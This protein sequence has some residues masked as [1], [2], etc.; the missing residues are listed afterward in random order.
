MKYFRE[1]LNWQGQQ[2]MM[3]NYSARNLP[4]QQQQHQFYLQQQQQVKQ[5]GMMYPQQAVSPA[6]MP[7]VSGNGTYYPMPTR[8]TS[9]SSQQ[10][11]PGPQFQYQPAT[12]PDQLRYNAHQQYQQ[13]QQQMMMMN[14][15]MSRSAPYPHP[16]EIAMKRRMAQQQQQQQP[17]NIQQ[18]PLQQVM[19]PMS[20][21]N[22]AQPNVT[23]YKVQAPVVSVGNNNPH[24]NREQGHVQ[25]PPQNN[26]QQMA[27][28]QAHHQQQL[29]AAQQ[30]R[31]QQQQQQQ[32]Q[33]QRGYQQI[34]SPPL[35]QHQPP[36]PNSKMATV[37]GP[38]VMSPQPQQIV[39]VENPVRQL[40]DTEPRLTLTVRD[41][42]ILEP[43]KLQHL[44]SVSNH[45]FLLRDQVFEMLM[46]RTK[47]F[48][49]QLKC[50]HNEDRFRQ[51]SWPAS[52]EV[53]VNNHRL[54]I[55]RSEHQQ[56]PQQMAIKNGATS[57]KPLF[58][59][60]MCNPGENL[61]TIS[62]S[63]CCCSHLFV[64]ELVQRPTLQNLERQIFQK[65]LLPK[66]QSIAK[67]KQVFFN[68]NNSAPDRPVLDQADQE[69]S[70][71]AETVPLRCPYT[72]QMVQIPTRSIECRHLRCFDLHNFLFVNRD[73]PVWQCP[74]CARPVGLDELEI[75]QFILEI[76]RYAQ[77]NS[78]SVCFLLFLLFQNAYFTPT[79]FS[80]DDG[81]FNQ[82]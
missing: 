26:P 59:K 66:D 46:D 8:T 14:S 18:S 6:M 78:T 36:Y 52:V 74:L 67:L 13:Q 33:A 3:P 64:L 76:I 29:I 20:P 82:C 44:L 4:P 16:H 62:V 11:P 58:I 7:V 79:T 56:T 39:K 43:F 40:E 71:T 73:K 31:L 65:K 15:H 35:Q 50:F 32:Q 45:K 72:N 21:M 12:T 2:Q 24:F 30:Q 27:M 10:Q 34:C 63:S 5:Q 70:V 81:C 48:E 42:T 22:A 25:L 41:G 19:S 23:P 51:T 60:N 80:I 9:A 17:G 61:L 55:D 54:L 57:T 77:Q 37:P 38:L 28:L 75:D 47:D 49:L 53:S 1:Q 69:S 68:S